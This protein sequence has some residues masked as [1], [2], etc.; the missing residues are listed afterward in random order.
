[1]RSMKDTVARMLMKDAMI[2]YIDVGCD[3]FIQ[4]MR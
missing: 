1:M 2:P 4:K 3:V